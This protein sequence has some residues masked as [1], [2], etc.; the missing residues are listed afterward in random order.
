ML[1]A[2]GSDD[3]DYE[4]HGFD[5][6]GKTGERFGSSRLS[7]ASAT[8][9][10]PPQPAE[11]SDDSDGSFFGSTGPKKS[12]K[13]KKEMQ[14][15]NSANKRKAAHSII[16]RNCGSRQNCVDL[17]SLDD[18]KKINHDF[19]NLDVDGQ[20]SFIQK[21]VSFA[22]V[23]DRRETRHAAKELRKKRSYVCTLPTASDVPVV[24][25]R[26]FFLNTIGFGEHCG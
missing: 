18:R 23:K 12:K 11:R 5:L 2:Y 9:R 21:Y 16:F 20:R 7:A 17:L 13:T 14:K 24:V 19:W 6:I 4:F 22:N 15:E 3:S 1:Q 26:T 8:E 25:C 10:L